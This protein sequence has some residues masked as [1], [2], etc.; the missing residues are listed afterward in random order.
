MTV[1]AAS[2]AA[3]ILAADESLIGAIG[4][5]VH[6]TT[7]LQHLAAAIKMASITIAR[8]CQSGS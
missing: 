2:V 1:G 7:N 6:A 5:V 8:A 4:G 3:P